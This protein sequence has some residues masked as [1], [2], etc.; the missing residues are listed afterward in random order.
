MRATGN[1]IVITAPS[2][3]GKTTIVHR[4]VAGMPEVVFSVSHTTRPIRAGE[5][6]GKDYC[7]VS[8]GEFARMR[9]ADAFYEWARVFGRH[10]YGTSRRFVDEHL[11]QGLDVLLEI[12]V[13][14]ALQIRQSAPRA[15]L[16]QILP[17]SFRVLHD[18]L[19]GRKTDAE[20][21]IR[22]RLE[23]ARQEILLFRNFD[24]V[25]I[26]QDLD[27]SVRSV[28]TIIEA[29]RHRIPENE[30]NVGRIL[31]TFSEDSI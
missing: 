16:I 1:L 5:V 2:G 23:T 26:N 13:Q 4:V 28:Q 22:R 14:G 27:E 31:T 3:T 18:R 15:V 19:A 11:R 20:E 24:Y 25:V 12:D 10:F 6:D 9:D 17:P 29:A 7:F 21:E 8:E 30:A